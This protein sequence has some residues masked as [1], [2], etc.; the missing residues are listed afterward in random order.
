MA[1][2]NESAHVRSR[3]RDA[4]GEVASR[5]TISRYS[6]EL[7]GSTHCCPLAFSGD[8]QRPAAM[9]EYPPR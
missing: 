6:M 9:L 2:H 7:A 4:N 8:C 5:A 1:G 3:K